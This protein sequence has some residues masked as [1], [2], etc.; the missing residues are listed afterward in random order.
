MKLKRKLRELK[1]GK[2]VVHNKLKKETM[3]KIF[4]D[5]KPPNG[6]RFAKTTQGNLIYVTLLPLSAPMFNGNNCSEC[7]PL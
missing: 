3:I 2:V 1:V 4:A 6:F 7:I 5:V